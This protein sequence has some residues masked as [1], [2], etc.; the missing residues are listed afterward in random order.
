MTGRTTSVVGLGPYILF[1]GA[2]QPLG[3]VQC[4]KSNCRQNIFPAC[5]TKAFV[6]LEGR[7]MRVDTFVKN[8]D[9]REAALSG[10]RVRPYLVRKGPNV[11]FVPPTS[12]SPFSPPVSFCLPQS[13]IPSL[14]PHSFL[15]FLSLRCLIPKSCP[16][17][18]PPFIHFTH[19]ENPALPYCCS[20]CI[21]DK[22]LSMSSMCWPPAPMGFGAQDL[23]TGI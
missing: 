1:S 21:L 17:I 15:D 7:Q 14:P 23:G 16:A 22:A 4:S 3:R 13:A 11:S 9:V 19:A 2:P 5:S 10:C 20:A 12:L 6:L 18:L 8:S